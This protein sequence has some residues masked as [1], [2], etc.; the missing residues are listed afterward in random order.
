MDENKCR[1]SV[2]CIQFLVYFLAG[3]I[4]GVLLFRWLSNSNGRWILQYGAAFLCP[5]HMRFDSWMFSVCRP[6]LLAFLTSIVPQ[7]SRLLP[8]LVVFR[9]VLMAYCACVFLSIGALPL[10]ICLRGAVVLILF[11]AASCWSWYRWS[12]HSFF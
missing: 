7:M 1:N 6:V 2:F 8:V 5:E 3:T 4:C 10:L 9:G 11:Y 12:C